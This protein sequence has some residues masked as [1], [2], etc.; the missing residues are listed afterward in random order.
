M[1]TK[2]D[3]GTRRGDGGL[4]PQK[5][6][7]QQDILEAAAALVAGQGPQALSVRSL[8]RAMGCSTQPIYSAF[9]SMDALHTALIDYVREH[10]LRAQ[11]SSY[12]QVAVSFLNFARSQKNLFRLVYLRQRPAGETRFE[13]PNAPET[14]HQVET[15][16]ELN[17]EKAADLYRRMVYYCYSMAVMMANDKKYDYVMPFGI[18][19]FIDKMEEYC[20]GG[21][22]SMTEFFELCNEVRDALEMPEKA[23]DILNAPNKCRACGCGFCP[24]KWLAGEYHVAEGRDGRR[25]ANRKF[26]FIHPC[27]PYPLSDMEIDVPVAY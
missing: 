2:K 24:S 6:I 26:G 19:V 17:R 13:D 21:R 18:Q 10:Y 14:I 20:P 12:K 15:S 9:E 8:A 11:A 1:V 5:R 3:S 27:V 4:P 25:E 22:K 7:F 16:L 23:K